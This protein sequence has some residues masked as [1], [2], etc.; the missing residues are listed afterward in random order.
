MILERQKDDSIQGCHQKKK[1]KY[2]MSFFKEQQIVVRKST[3]R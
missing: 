3:N 1:N 2:K